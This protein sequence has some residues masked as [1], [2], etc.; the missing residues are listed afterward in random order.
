MDPCITVVYEEVV[1]G[2]D[3]P[4]NVGEMPWEVVGGDDGRA[5]N[6]G[7]RGVG[8]RRRWRRS[9]AATASRAVEEF[10]QRA[11][12]GGVGRKSFEEVGRGWFTSAPRRG[13]ADVF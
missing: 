7:N 8:M 13:R 12:N 6:G 3:L 10:G 9:R 4:V 2:E 5:E 1:I 11:E